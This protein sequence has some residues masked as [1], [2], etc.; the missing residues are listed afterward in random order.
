MG[1]RTPRRFVPHGLEVG[2][3]HHIIVGQDPG[4]LGQFGRIIETHLDAGVVQ[5]EILEDRRAEFLYCDVDVHRSAGAA[6]YAGRSNT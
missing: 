4:E 5:S 3:I 1:F 6:K 2:R